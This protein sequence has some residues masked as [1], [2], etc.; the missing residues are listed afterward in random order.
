MGTIGHKPHGHH[1]EQHPPLL[2][3]LC[4]LEIWQHPAPEADLRRVGNF[5]PEVT[6]HYVSQDVT[7][8]DE[9]VP[10][11]LLLSQTATESAI[12]HAQHACSTV[13]ILANFPHPAD[14]LE[15]GADATCSGCG[16]VHKSENQLGEL[17]LVDL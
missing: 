7:L 12:A 3:M 6:V 2:E 1:R 4:L 15:A 8:T 16:A 5:P 13:L 11:F 17:C 14:T 10:C 9:Q